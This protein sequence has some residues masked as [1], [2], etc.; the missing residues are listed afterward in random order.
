M[1]LKEN[2]KIR[3]RM[4]FEFAGRDKEG[5]NGN[6]KK[7]IDNLR[8]KLDIYKE[9]YA[10][11]E[12]MDEKTYATH[13]EIEGELPS[14]KEVFIV[15]LLFEPSIIEVIEPSEFVIP[16]GEM[17]DI[18]ADVNLKMNQMEQNMRVIAA[19][20]KHST[21]LLKTCEKKLEIKKEAENDGNTKIPKIII[22]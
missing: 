16:A 13:V 3:V 18:L 15:T 8:E 11:P 7:M 22:E 10:E 12:K 19:R 4:F 21:N 9:E 14:V 5:L 1:S 17:Q 20:L 2:G 6:L